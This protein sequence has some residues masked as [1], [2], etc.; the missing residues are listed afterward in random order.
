MLDWHDAQTIWEVTSIE[1]DS[2]RL[3]EDKLGEFY[4]YG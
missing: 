3:F 1:L 2:D 4:L